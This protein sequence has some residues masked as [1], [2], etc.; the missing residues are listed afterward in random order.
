MR[1]ADVKFGETDIGLCKITNTTITYTRECFAGDK[2]SI[3]LRSGK[4]RRVGSERIVFRLP[5]HGFGIGIVQMH[6]INI[7]P[8]DE[9]DSEWYYVAN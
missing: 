9:P 7:I 2:R 4:K 6:G 3:Q 5:V 8:V 1:I